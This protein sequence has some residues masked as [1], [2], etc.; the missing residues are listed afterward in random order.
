MVNVP[1]ILNIAFTEFQYYNFNIKARDFKI[2]KLNIR[3]VYLQLK[4][5]DGLKIRF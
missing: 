1:F 2:Y 3:G 4:D 5:P